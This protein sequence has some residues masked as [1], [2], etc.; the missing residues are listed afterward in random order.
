MKKIYLQ[1]QTEVENISMES[2]IMAS[3]LGVGEGE[4]SPENADA[5][6]YNIFGA[7]EF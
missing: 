1:P 2:L 7:F 3:Q 5:R 6:M 4:K